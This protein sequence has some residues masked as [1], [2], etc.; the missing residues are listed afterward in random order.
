[1]SEITPV[2]AATVVLVR[3]T[4]QDSGLQVLLLQRNS[5]RD[6]HGGHWV[7]PGGRIDEADFDESE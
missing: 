1:M 5:R 2:P 4:E 7:F 6:F 3:E